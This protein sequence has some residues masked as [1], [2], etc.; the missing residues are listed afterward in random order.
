MSLC[1]LNSAEIRSNLGNSELAP[2]LDRLIH[3]SL[4]SREIG[5]DIDTVQ[6]RIG[7]AGLMKV[8]L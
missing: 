7:G 8:I 2:F 4:C 1:D 5:D 3:I 6:K